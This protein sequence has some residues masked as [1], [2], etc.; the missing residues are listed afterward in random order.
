MTE[1][2]NTPPQL[3]KINDDF[4]CGIDLRDPVHSK[5]YMLA[6]GHFLS[7]WPQEWDAETLALALLAEED[8]ES[9]EKAFANQ[10]EIVV[11]GVLERDPEFQSYQG[12]MYLENL[13]NNLAEDFVRFASEVSG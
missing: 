12:H 2:L 5:A 4:S 13:I 10:K 8:V 11:W 3:I 7:S 9:D 1:T 6:A